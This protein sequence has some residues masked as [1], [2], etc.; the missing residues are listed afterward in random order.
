VLVAKKALLWRKM[1][2]PIEN[3]RARKE[4]LS[5]NYNQMLT[6]S[7]IRLRCSFQKANFSSQVVRRQ[8]E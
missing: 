5:N 7:G 1:E 3:D 8:S 6:E 4:V 2:L